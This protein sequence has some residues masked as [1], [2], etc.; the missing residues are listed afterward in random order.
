MA[1]YCGKIGFRSTRETEPGIWTEGIVERTYYGDLI[2]FY[3][4][5][6][7]SDKVNSDINISNQISIVA[8]AYA[9]NNC[10]A[11]LYA[12]FMGAKWMVNSI[13]V[14]YPRLI[15]SLGGLYNDN[16]QS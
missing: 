15:L 12:E 10:F 1:K 7:S 14:N 4:R 5:T 11:I 2:R 6:E 9:N 16:N 13:D 8:D 3:K